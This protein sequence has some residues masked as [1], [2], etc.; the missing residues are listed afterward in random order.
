MKK[1][2]KRYLL[3]MFN[4]QCAYCGEK[5]PKTLDHVF[6][7]ALGGTDDIYNLVPACFSCNVNKGKNNLNE[8]YNKQPFYCQIRHQQITH[9]QSFSDMV[10]FYEWWYRHS[11]FENLD[12]PGYKHPGFEYIAT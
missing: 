3:D 6:P 4:D 12:F 8:W 5:H 10:R 7:K 11:H 9:H 1:A 2:I